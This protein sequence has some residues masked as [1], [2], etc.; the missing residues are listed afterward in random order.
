MR[1][2]ETNFY[3]TAEG[4][5]REGDR[6]ADCLAH[7]IF[8]SPEKMYSRAYFDTKWQ[9]SDKNAVREAQRKHGREPKP[10]G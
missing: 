1:D 7:V 2:E 6:P 10:Y 3:L 5:Q 9:H 8:Y 4:W